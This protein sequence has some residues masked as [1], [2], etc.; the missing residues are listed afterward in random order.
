MN[1]G[2]LNDYRIN[3]N[4]K[5]LNNYLMKMKNLQN[6]YEFKIP[7]YILDEII[8]NEDK[9]NLNVLINLA[10]MNYELSKEDAKILKKKYCFFNTTDV[11]TQLTKIIETYH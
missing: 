11:R 4:Q 1:Q 8:T 7:K 5:Q 9:Y 10:V 2:N 3:I 6:L